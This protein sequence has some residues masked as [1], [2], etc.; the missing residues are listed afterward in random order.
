M[1]EERK[2]LLQHLLT[3]MN[4]LDDLK[5]SLK[6]VFEREQV[7]VRD[8]LTASHYIFETDLVK[9]RLWKLLIALENKMME[10]V[11]A[12]VNAN[13]S[14]PP[15]G[16]KP[17]PSLTVELLVLGSRLNRKFLDKYAALFNNSIEQPVSIREAFDWLIEDYGYLLIQRR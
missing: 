12:K 16:Y 14:L 13:Y 8:K 2:K 15:R 1:V 10:W 3:W 11:N 4:D 9:A 6:A 5:A 7:A 17:S